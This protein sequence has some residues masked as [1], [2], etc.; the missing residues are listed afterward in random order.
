[1][2]LQ[3]FYCQHRTIPSHPSQYEIKDKHAVM[4]SAL[5]VTLP[6]NLKAGSK[7]QVETVYSTTEGCLA[8]QWLEKECVFYPGTWIMLT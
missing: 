1:M 2:Q 5:H 6:A 8:L 7:L 4:G 3:V